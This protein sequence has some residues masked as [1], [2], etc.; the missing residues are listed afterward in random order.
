MRTAIREYGW[1]WTL[2]ILAAMAL[3][4]CEVAP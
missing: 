1:L 2:L 3:T 4:M